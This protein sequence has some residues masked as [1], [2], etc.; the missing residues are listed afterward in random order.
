MIVSHK[1]EFIFLKTRKT[2]GTSIEVFL[3]EGCGDQDIVTEI[4]PE[5]SNHR[6]RN[7]RG[8][9]SPFESAARQE[10]FL[11]RLRHAVSFRRYYNHMPAELVKAR[12]GEDIWNRYFK[13]CVERNPWDK[14]VSM[15]YMYLKRSGKE[16]SFEQFVD[17]YPRLPVNYGLY[18]D[19]QGNLMV[20]RLLRYESLNDELAAVFQSLGVPFEGALQQR[21]KSDYRTEQGRYQDMYTSGSRNRVAEIY[22]QEIDLLGYEFD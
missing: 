9:A 2:A 7:F 1:H 15:Y 11:R 4:F 13:F 8:I 17:S 10:P 22:K 3:S 18:S 16:I 14:T 21:A 5:E 6:P 12:V 20:D 19:R